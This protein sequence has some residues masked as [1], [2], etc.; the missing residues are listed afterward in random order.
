MAGKK[1]AK[2]AILTTIVQ[3]GREV[4]AK[5]C[6]KCNV[7]KPLDDFYKAPAGIGKRRPKCITC[8]S[9][10][11]IKVATLK[12]IIIEGVTHKA[13]ECS[14]CKTVQPL[15]HF[16]KGN[17]IG[18]KAA[19]CKSCLSKRGKEESKQA[20]IERKKIKDVE[21][22]MFFDEEVLMNWTM[23][24]DAP[25]I[26]GE[27]CKED[28]IFRKVTTEEGY[29]SYIPFPYA[30]KVVTKQNQKKQHTKW[31]PVEAL[32]AG[33][34]LSIANLRNIPPWEG[35]GNFEQG[36]LL[37]EMLGDGGLSGDT[38]HAYLR[39]WGE[40]KQQLADIAVDRVKRQLGARYDLTGAYSEVNQ[41][42]SVT[43]SRLTELAAVFGLGRT[44]EITPHIEMASYDFYRGFIRGFFDADGSVQGSHRKGI[45]VRLNQS[46]LAHLKKIQR[47]LLRLGIGSKIYE[48][49]RK[50]EYRMMP[51]GK[52]GLKSYYC[53]ANHE[54]VIAND[55]IIRYHTLIG[56]EEPDKAK[57]LQEGIESFKRTPNRE[58]FRVK[59]KSISTEMLA[60]VYPVI[61]T[62]KESIDINGLL[63][64]NSL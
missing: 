51:D 26:I 63:I 8:M 14:D 9:P 2:H 16:Y 57:K 56:F 13:K 6:N 52:G 35:N 53:Q 49:R 10:T 28:N 41:A 23:K 17:G 50:E 40:S 59:V 1:G 25:Q 47:M 60:N 44:K 64:S 45:S 30:I 31:I 21:T 4:L 48:N 46:N 11:G 3:N 27:T 29:E 37:G 61:P 43:A 55:N 7:V 18:G 34:F 58:R 20:A 36:W 38:H 62:Y 33:D 5:R 12:E 32:Q 42:I 22:V 54:L 24:E 39:F 19:R 15:E